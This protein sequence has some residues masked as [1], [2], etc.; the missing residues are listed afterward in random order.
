VGDLQQPR[1]YHFNYAVS[2]PHTGDHKSQWEVKEKGV[3]RGAYSLLEPDGT[4]RVVEYIA[5]DHGFRAVVKKLGTAVHPEPVPVVP[6]PLPDVSHFRAYDGYVGN[7]AS[8][9]NLGGEQVLLSQPQALGYGT[10]GQGQYGLDQGQHLGRVEVVQVQPQFVPHEVRPVLPA[11]VQGQYRLDLGAVER[12]RVELHQPVPVGI[13]NNLGGVLHQPVLPAV[14]QEQYRFEAPRVETHQL[15]F[16]QQVPHQQIQQEQYRIEAPRVETHQFVLPQKV[17]EV[18]HQQVQ[19]EQYRIE[20]PRVQTQ[21]FVLP[22]RVEEVPRIDTSQVVLPAQSYGNGIPQGHYRVEG[23]L[24]GVEA[25]P[26]IESQQSVL[27]VH[28]DGKIEQGQYLNRDGVG[29]VPGLVPISPS[30]RTTIEYHGLTGNPEDDSR[31]TNDA[32]RGDYSQRVTKVVPAP[33]AKGHSE[34][35]KESPVKEQFLIYYPESESH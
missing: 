19:P 27:P 10:I 26:R 34:Q 3:V 35:K 2:D 11:L 22:Q 18:P 1:D 17:E 15:V 12:P 14:P 32:Y 6:Q 8:V 31:Y 29:A 21:E 28:I 33:V 7:Y 16:P 30:Y 25:G 5:D 9:P 24:G 23:G 20:A 13:E 4:T